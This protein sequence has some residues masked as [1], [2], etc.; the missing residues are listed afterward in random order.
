MIG[1][2]VIGSF[3]SIFISRRRIGL[4]IIAVFFF[5]A[6]LFFWITILTISSNLYLNDASAIVFHAAIV[7]TLLATCTAS[8]ALGASFAMKR[9]VQITLPY[10]FNQYPDVFKTRVTK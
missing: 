6:C 9:P 3:V 2:A 7:F 8:Y 1:L 10:E 4:I 5:L